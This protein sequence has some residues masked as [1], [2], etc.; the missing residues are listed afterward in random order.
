M[1]ASIRRHQKWLLIVIVS[2]VI[3]SFVILMDPS[4]SGRKG[5][6]ARGARGDFGS[7]N[8]RALTREEV[9]QAR[10][11]ARLR[12]YL[13]YGRWPEQDETTRQMYDEDRELAQ[14]LFLIE[15]IR[16]LE[17]RV[18]ESA[19]AD[20]IA[21]NF[22]DRERGQFRMEM[23]QQ[24][25]Q[26]VLHPAGYTEKEFEAYVR[27]EVGIQHLF[28]LGGLSGSLIIPREAEALF[29]QENEQLTAEV[30]LF[31]ASNY[32]ASVKIEDAALQQYFTNNMAR[33][34]IPER[35]QAGYVKFDL[36]NYLAAADQQLAQRTNLTTELQAEY[37]RRG[38]EWFKDAEGKTM[39]QE[40]AL[41]KVKEDYR[42]GLAQAEARRNATTFAEHLYEQHEKQP[43]QTN[44]LELVAAALGYVAAVTEPFTRFEGPKDLRVPEVFTQVAFAL[45]PEQ[46]LASEPIPG[47]DAVFVIAL[48]RK[49]P[50]ELQ[51]FASVQEKVAEDYRR[52]E[53]MEAG[54]QAGQTF[55]STLTN[56]LA[57]GKSFET[58]CAE[59]KV[60]PARLPTFSPSTRSLPEWEGRIDLSLVKDIASSLAPGKTSEFI[61][62]RDG[63]MV[64]RL[65]SRQAVDPNKLTTELPAFVER[66]RE[67]RQ[68]QAFNDWFRKEY[69]RARVSGLPTSKKSSASSSN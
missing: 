25:L 46:P 1:F 37:V 44:N 7:I 15:K 42:K 27:H 10:D 36:T 47:E 18:S 31:S 39:A 49:L 56:G 28:A 65:I 4:Y 11:E 21:R 55:Y 48:K 35:V 33:Y 51:S 63:G 24:V 8:G 60:E 59:A 62:T 45:T 40:A 5:R 68:R 38:A 14:R 69:D 12:F 13:S 29:R 16:D 26:R 41:Q 61:P 22:R 17:V 32:L 30:V 9:N 3:I 54:R 50:S 58:I 53:A 64:L 6:L 57:Q 66:L 67:E 34:R 20:W 52:R 23:Y 19:V 43:G 2:L